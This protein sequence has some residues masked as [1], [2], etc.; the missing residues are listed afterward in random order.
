MARNFI[1]KMNQIVVG[2]AERE[3]ALNAGA[4]LDTLMMVDASTIFLAEPRRETNIDELTGR[5]EA[6]KSYDMGFLSNFA[7]PFGKGM[8]QHFAFGLAYGLGNPAAG[9]AWGGG[10]KHVIVPE[11]GNAMPSFSAGMREGDTINK[12]KLD[13]LFVD[14][15]TATFA[16]DEWLKLNLGIKG[17]GKHTNSVVKET[18]T[19]AFNATTLTLAANGVQDAGDNAAK[20]LD[21]V[22]RIR[23]LTPTTGEYAD[24]VYTAVSNAVPAAITI[25]AP[26]VAATSTTYEIIYLPVEAGWMTFP[27]P[28]EES[29]M[30]TTDLVVKVGGKWNGSAYLGGHDISIECDSVEYALTNDLVVEYRPGGTGLYASYAWRRQRH[31]T[32]KIVRESRDFSMRQLM[33]DNAHFAIS[34]KATG[35]EFETGK[36][37]YVEGICPD[38]NITKVSLANNDKRNVETV[39]A[40]V[41]DGGTY[42][43][44]IWTVANEVAAYGQIPA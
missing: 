40:E 37:F 20:R 29:P 7:M 32:V 11:L 33:E 43:T 6:D 14:T 17:T 44:S 13:G 25:V 12:M 35:A 4:D 36:N 42:A 28:V 27:S 3:S 38:C 30:R 15:L 26:G 5:E 22:Q 8:P 1:A 19:A 16:K 10:F 24:V 31:Q 41:M 39:E 34:M 9:S 2:A 23:V 18:V 21:N